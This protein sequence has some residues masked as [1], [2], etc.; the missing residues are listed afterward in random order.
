MAKVILSDVGNVVVGFDNYKVCK[1]IARYCDYDAYFIYLIIYHG[2]HRLTRK[3][4][5]GLISTDEFREMVLRRFGC[6]GT[7]PFGEFDDAFSRV[8]TLNKDVVRLW[9]NL[10][11]AGVIITAIS[12][13][14][15]L[16]REELDRLG[17]MSLFNYTVLSYK[18]KIAKPNQKM[19][20]LGLDRS[21]VQPDGAVYIDDI[22]E[23]V[24]EARNLGIV[25]HHYRDYSGLN[26]F[27]RE[28]GFDLDS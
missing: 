28:Q 25:A 13:M 2:P 8:F 10:N 23:Y 19:W 11:R 24:N 9:F 22:P 26:K 4:T 20:R 17:V 15:E 21:G 16:R 3:Y 18:E 6:L 7:M 14:E 5:R 27:L 1:A 12:D